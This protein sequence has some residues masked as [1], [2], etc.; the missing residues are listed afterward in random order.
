ME[1]EVLADRAWEGGPHLDRNPVVLRKG[2]EPR[3]SEV[4]AGAYWASTAR[5]Q[6]SFRT[7]T[8]DRSPPG[9]QTRT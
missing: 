3:S 1:I 4:L 9:R 6:C 5:V 2:P 8:E 7:Y